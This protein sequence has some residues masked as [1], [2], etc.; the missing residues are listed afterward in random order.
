MLVYF[1]M[2]CCISRSPGFYYC[3]SKTVASWL[4]WALIVAGEFSRRGNFNK[5]CFSPRCST[6]PHHLSSREVLEFLSSGAV[7]LLCH[8]SQPPGLKRHRTQDVSRSLNSLICPLSC[9]PP[10]TLCKFE[11]ACLTPSI[12]W[13]KRMKRVLLLPGSDNSPAQEKNISIF[14]YYHFK[15]YNTLLS[16]RNSRSLGK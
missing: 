6:E 13:E 10:E 2:V 5:I 15:S 1:A 3:Q 14:M 7:L 4:D 12:R 9:C 16:S 8:L 11:E